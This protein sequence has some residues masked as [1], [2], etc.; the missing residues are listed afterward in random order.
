MSTLTW[1]DLGQTFDGPHAT[2][3]R[4]ASGPYFLNIASLKSGRLD[5][6]ESDHVSDADFAQ[7]T[8]RVAPRPDDLLFSYETRL[9]EAALM[10]D[11]VV[12][13]LGRRMALLRPDISVVDPRF[14][15]Y[16]FLSPGFQKLIA[17]RAVH[18]ATVDRIPLSNMG[19][20]PVELPSMSVQRGIA[21]VLGAFD[22]KIAA[23]EQLLH[24][25]DD[26]FNTE[27]S[28][29]YLSS[30]SW[31]LVSLSSVVSTQYGLTASATDEPEGLKFLR[32]TDI[33]KRNWI[34]WDAV[35]TVP[36]AVV[37]ESKYVLRRGD[38]VVARMAD[39][40]KSALYE[41]DVPA[42]FASYLV[43]L[44][45]RSWT[46]GLFIYG[47]LKSDLYARYADSAMTGSV[48]RNMNAR[49][50]AAAELKWPPLEVL[51]SFESN[52]TP[53]R[54]RMTSV[55]A[56]SAALARTR[57]ELLPLLMSGKL[58]VKDAEKRAEE[59]L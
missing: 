29:A 45:P 31:P 37:D 12:G 25:A 18:G 5:L 24:A 46:E 30:D 54:S 44:S 51:Q 49:V 9:G 35:P 50:I 48:Q 22:D 14:L 32:V 1:Q 43:R 57:D 23:N 7:W 52:G 26:L 27:W 40:G 21:E 58:T 33:N 10:P 15:L 36:V 42:V 3:T 38:I 41:G 2:P 56:E 39:P 17:E 20:W 59:V 55:V 53:L 4:R 6:S 47:Y 28:R 8:K 34:T 13:C 16:F 11:G 19:S